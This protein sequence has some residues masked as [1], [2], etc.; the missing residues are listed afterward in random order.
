MLTRVVYACPD[1]D[2]KFKQRNDLNTMNRHHRIH[3]GEKPFVCPDCD[4]K[5]KDSFTMNLHR[6]EHTGEKPFVCP[7]CDKTFK[8]N[9]HLNTH[10]VKFTLAKSRS[11][12][13]I[14]TRRSNEM[15]DCILILEFTLFA[16]LV[17]TKSS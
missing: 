10:I 5:F 2:K 16:F 1:C 3:T 4:T 8:R 12:V 7:D 13:L 15:E 14:V 9:D 6:R 17:A 11:P